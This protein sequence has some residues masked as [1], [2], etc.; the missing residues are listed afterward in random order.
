MNKEN[1]AQAQPQANYPSATAI[2]SDDQQNRPLVG[3]VT[4][5]YS[6]PYVYMS[7]PN[8]LVPVTQ[9][10]PANF[11]QPTAYFQTGTPALD[12]FW[13]PWTFDMVFFKFWSLW[14]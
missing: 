2:V 10:L 11:F 6:N 12:L 8:N 5:F 1:S 3:N 14:S 4:D 9:G 7:D 13:T